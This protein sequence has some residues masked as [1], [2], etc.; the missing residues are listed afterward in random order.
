MTPE[1]F[2]SHLFWI[3]TWWQDFVDWEDGGIFT[4][5]SYLEKKPKGPTKA[6]LMHLRQ[7]YDYAVG[8][9]H[10]Y[11]DG[12][13]VASHLLNTFDDI[14]PDKQ[15]ALI[16][17]PFSRRHS[18]KTISGYNNAYAVIC[19]SRVAVALQNR[20]AAERALS[21]YQDLDRFFTDGSLEERGTWT[22]WD[23]ES[24]TFRQKTD[25]A[26]IH[27]C[28]GAFNLYRALKA[29][30]PDLASTHRDVL[31]QQCLDM[32]RFFATHIARPEEGFTVEKLNDDG[33]TDPRQ[34]H[35]NQ[36]LAHGFEWLGFLFE[37]EH[38]FG[39]EVPFLS[40]RGAMLGRNTLHN[41]LAENGCFRNEWIPAL[42]RAPLMATFWP[43][44]ESIL[45]SIWCR[46]RWGEKQFPLEEAERMMDF[47]TTYM[48]KPDELGGG[49]LTAVSEN[50][51]P[52]YLSVTS[53]VKCDH[54]AVRMC[55]KILDYRLLDSSP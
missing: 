49:I 25:N 9:D 43:Q 38:L 11:P 23:L 52:Q 36:S 44:V 31:L 48:F 47:Y 27:R 19:F 45:G 18:G 8:H 15:G 42:S 39:V 40:E 50:G 24:N 10:G 20:A 51:V 46:N 2:H 4:Y 6:L 17:E 54:H 21:I 53:A 1:Y 35:N 16:V 29:T 7:M 13:K 22:H 5:S 55:E 26:L 12:E 28:E 33:S 37:I 14:F 41:G 3:L 32:V 30:A 34:L